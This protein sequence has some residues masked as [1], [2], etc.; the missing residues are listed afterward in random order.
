[1]YVSLLPS[2]KESSPS[3]NAPPRLDSIL[4]SSIWLNCECNIGIL[5]ASLPMLRPLL[6]NNLTRSLRSRFSGSRSNAGSRRLQ[7]LEAPENTRRSSTLVG[8]NG[9]GGGNG[10]QTIYQGGGIKGQKTWYNSAVSAMA[11]ASKHDDRSSEGS[12]EGMV[13]MGKIAVRRDL[14]WNDNKDDKGAD[15]APHAA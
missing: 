5:S 14:D 7:D 4:N 6:S 15:T 12:Q 11:M 9:S 1:M 3:D 13:P 10:G 2:Q 8:S